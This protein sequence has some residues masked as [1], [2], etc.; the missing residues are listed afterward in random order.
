MF[1]PQCGKENKKESVFCFNCGNNLQGGSTVIP[2]KI[3]AENNTPKKKKSNSALIVV[4]IIA[5]VAIITLG[6]CACGVIFMFIKSTNSAPVRRE[7]EPVTVA[8]AVVAEVEEP[9]FEEMTEMVLAEETDV[10]GIYDPYLRAGMSG[11]NEYPTYTKITNEKYSYYCDVPDNFTQYEF[12]DT[13]SYVSE[14]YTAIMK[15]ASRVN[16]DGYTAKEVLNM[17]IE[18]LGGYV[19]YS[20]SKN[21]WFALSVIVD[22]DMCYYI[23]GYAEE[24]V[25][26]FIFYFPYEYIDIYDDY[27][28]HIEDNFKCE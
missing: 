12:G 28:E 20:T 7:A 19:H 13:K 22:E 9:I 26:E 27:I 3:K 11:L 25:R 14:D 23:K 6:I 17:R 15:I 18:E 8:T 24:Y 10:V 1:C 21:D 2:E 5:L 4:L 16:Y